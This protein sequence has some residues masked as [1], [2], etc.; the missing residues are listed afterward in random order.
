MISV[1]QGSAWYPPHYWGGTEVYLTGL[2][3]ALRAHGALSRIVAPLAPRAQ[4]G[5]EFD[6]ATVRTYPV[7]VPV[8]RADFR[9]RP[10]EGFSRFCEILRQEK[11]DIY[12]QHSWSRGLGAPHLNAAREMGI[13]TV[14]TVHVSN[15]ICL[16]GTM[17]RFGQRACDGHIDVQ[18][19]AACWSHARDA[20][21][22]LAHI[23][24]RVPS[25]LG[26]G[27]RRAG[28]DGRVATALS[29]RHVAS[30]HRTEFVDMV[31]NADCIVAVS[32]WLY[33]ALARNSVPINKLVLIPQAIDERFAAAAAAV[34]GREKRSSVERCFRLLYV[35]RWHPMKGIEIL[36]H[37]VRGIPRSVS[38][39]LVIHGVGDGPEERAHEATVRGL[40]E[41]DD[42]IR[43]APP[44]ARDRLAETL[45]YGS[46]L[47]VPSCCLEVS[48]IVV[49]EAKAVGLPII[50]SR[51]GG[52]AEL[53]HEPDDGLLVAP[54]DVKAWTQAI[55]SMATNLPVAKSIRNG[56]EL[57]TMRDVAAEMAAVYR[58]ILTPRS[59]F[60][61][62]GR[63]SR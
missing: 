59:R 50:G 32:R 21:K 12:H 28:L 43:I 46:A 6:G 52:I 9:S 31:A 25:C 37:A 61:L 60:A 53:V 1:L 58:E 35:G 45:S 49:L 62:V 39:E 3:R 48:P 54:G 20:P 15:N 51:L 13:K 40:A 56:S 5:Y 11:P 23:L 30:E 63:T 24:A 36:V 29:A 55:L 17:M 57:R 19:C 22:P 14:V 2:V 38:L 44:V 10:H 18:K 34:H 33:D 27:L 8:S 47:A 16:R 42:R 41:S 4:D 7:N 26:L